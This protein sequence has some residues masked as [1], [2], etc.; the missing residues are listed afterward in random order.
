MIDRPKLAMFLYSDLHSDNMVLSSI[1]ALKKDDTSV[2]FI[3]AE[4]HADD[5]IESIK[6]KIILAANDLEIS[7]SGLY[8]FCQG[9]QELDAPGVY[10]ML[11][12]V[13]KLELS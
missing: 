13:G 7:Y 3:N 5:T 9:E 6:K 1:D 2:V 11:T 8:I 10:Q 4:I 12:Q